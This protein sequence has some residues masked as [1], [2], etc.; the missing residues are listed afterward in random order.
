MDFHIPLT[1]SFASVQQSEVCSP[2]ALTSLCKDWASNQS[3]IKNNMCCVFI[4]FGFSLIF[5][6]NDEV[7]NLSISLTH[8][9]SV[10]RK[11]LYGATG[12]RDEIQSLSVIQVCGRQTPSASPLFTG[13]TLAVRSD[14][15]GSGFHQG[16]CPGVCLSSINQSCFS[17]L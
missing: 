4:P 9:V 6:R 10:C 11:T 3:N 12:T 17:R 1:V 7:I 5:F 14:L 8:P 16:R 15:R 13:L 2:A